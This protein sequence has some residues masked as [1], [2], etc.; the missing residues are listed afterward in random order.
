[1]CRHMFDWNI[2]KYDL[3]KPKKKCYHLC[4]RNWL[5]YAIAT[6]LH[7]SKD[8]PHGA[9]YINEAYPRDFI[10]YLIEETNVKVSRCFDIGCA[11]QKC[12][13]MENKANFGSR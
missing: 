13:R 12:Q 5:I 1:M 2:A 4:I 3:N 10:G 9:I 11:G 7:V 6:D 8:I